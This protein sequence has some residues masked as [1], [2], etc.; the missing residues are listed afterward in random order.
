MSVCQQEEEKVE[1]GRECCRREGTY[2]PEFK[3]GLLSLAVVHP[4]LH[5]PGPGGAPVLTMVWGVFPEV[6]QDG[7]LQ[8]PTTAPFIKPCPQY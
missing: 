4:L 2:G 1:V 8:V 6:T 7:S 3:S 5:P